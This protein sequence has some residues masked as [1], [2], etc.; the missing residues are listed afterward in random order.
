MPELFPFYGTEGIERE[1]ISIKNRK[2]EIKVLESKPIQEYN[3][4]EKDQ[5]QSGQKLRYS[6]KEFTISDAIGEDAKWAECSCIP[7]IILIQLYKTP[8]N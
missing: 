2:K 5:S 4:G 1:N 8:R 7:M 6:K 3:A